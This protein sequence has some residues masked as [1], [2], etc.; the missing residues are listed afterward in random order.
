VGFTA[1]HRG[2]GITT[3]RNPR[4]VGE[5]AQAVVLHDASGVGRLVCADLLR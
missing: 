4:R 2:N 3:V 5:G 1:D